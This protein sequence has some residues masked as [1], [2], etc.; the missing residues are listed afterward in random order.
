MSEL[1]IP[2]TTL[3]VRSKQPKFHELLIKLAISEDEVERYTEE[4]YVK[5]LIPLADK[6]YGGLDYEPE[7]KTLEPDIHKYPKL[8]KVW[9]AINSASVK[10]QI[11]LWRSVIKSDLIT[12]NEI[13]E[14][15]YDLTKKVEYGD[16]LNVY[17]SYY[18]EFLIDLLDISRLA[19]KNEDIRN[20]LT[21]YNILKYELNVKDLRVID[22]LSFF[23]FLL[24]VPIVAVILGRSRYCTLRGMIPTISWITFKGIVR[25]SE[26][27]K[28]LASY[29]MDFLFPLV[30]TFGDNNG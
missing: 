16:L 24:A 19:L 18:E 1:S 29:Y 7:I 15:F 4:L 9:K 23:R 30:E 21:N 25:G 11:K 14:R 28:A 8:Y 12:L 2:V 6:V 26:K 10:T 27:D 3:P 22:L 13:K 5:Y 17:Y 20:I